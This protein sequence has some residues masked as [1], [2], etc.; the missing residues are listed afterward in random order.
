MVLPSVA[1]SF[2]F[3]PPVL[4]S[5]RARWSAVWFK[6]ELLRIPLG[7]GRASPASAATGCGRGALCGLAALCRDSVDLGWV[8][9]PWV[10]EVRLTRS[11]AK[12]QDSV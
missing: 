8:L 7:E 1:E 4:F 2:I 10:G 9:G 5:L 11:P 12:G 6:A 3:S